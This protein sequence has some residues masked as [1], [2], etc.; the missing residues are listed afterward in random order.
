MAV[1]IV[2][3]LS[4]K[5]NNP[6]T[7]AL[8]TA[9]LTISFSGLLK[10]SARLQIASQPKNDQKIT[11]IAFPTENHPFGTKGL[12]FPHCILGNATNTAD[13]KRISNK[14]LKINAT[15]PLTFTP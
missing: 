5:N 15:L 9:P 7:T 11:V 13:A 3:R 14:E 2:T 1:P 4:A 6:M 8:I 10:C 12:K